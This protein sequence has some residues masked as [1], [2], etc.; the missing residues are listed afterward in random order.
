[1]VAAPT[2]VG[3]TVFVVPDPSGPARSVPGFS[4]TAAVAPASIAAG[5]GATGVAEY[6]A[7]AACGSGGFADTLGG[8]VVMVRVVLVDCAC[9]DGT[10]VRFGLWACTSA[11]E[12]P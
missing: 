11:H 1:M 9:M 8:S 2:P 7:G 3:S 5:P 6:A 4:G 10:V 12:S